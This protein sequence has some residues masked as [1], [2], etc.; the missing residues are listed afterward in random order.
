LRPRLVS[1]S[2]AR[3][4][5]AV[6]HDLSRL[7][8]AGRDS[9]HSPAAFDASSNRPAATSERARF[10]PSSTADAAARA[11]SRS[12]RAASLPGSLASTVPAVRS[13]VAKSSASYAVSAVFIKSAI[14]GPGGAGVATDDGVAG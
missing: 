5:R 10:N 3:A 6:L 8:V 12:W 11:R 2:A 4:L 1:A 13:A 9:K 7:A 14:D